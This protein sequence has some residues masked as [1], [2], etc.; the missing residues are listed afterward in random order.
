M[1]DI[2]KPV[3]G[4]ER[5]L[6]R[7]AIRTSNWSERWFPASLI[8]A[9]LVVIIVAIAAI[10]IGAPPPV[11][12]KSFGDGFWSMIT[13]TMQMAMVTI[14][15]YVVADSPP[16]KRLINALAR[17]PKTGKGAVSLVAFLS[18]FT[19]L[20]NWGMSLIFSGILVRRLADRDDLRVDYKAASAAGYLGLGATWALGL[21]SSAAQLQANPASIPDT[22]MKVTGVIPFTDT[23]F[24]WQSLTMAA[25]LLVMSNVIAHVTA[26]NDKNAKTAADLGI[27]TT[28][29]EPPP[30]SKSRPGE[31]LE[32]NPLLTII[33]G[34]LAIGWMIQ[35]FASQNFIIAISGLNTY[36]L[37][38]LTLGL[39][40]HWRPYRFIASVA[41]A[42]PAVG[43]VLIQ[44]PFYAGIATVMTDATNS[45]G[46]SVSHLLASMF[47]SLGHNAW[48]F[49]LVI[50]VYSMILGFLVPSGGGKWLVE[51]PYVMDA[52]NQTHYSLGWTVQIY[53]ASE[54][55][56][57]LINPFWMLPLLGVV[58]LKPRDI[59]GYTFIQLIFH[60]PVILLCLMLFGHT[61]PYIPPMIP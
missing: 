51:A 30:A 21:S 56:P 41:K 46:A 7:L 43:G 28:D 36:N 9:F 20:L 52:A 34:V 60:L 25:I 1:S 48:I 31:W 15:G 10:C 11:V 59:V 33:I 26:P 32:H 29:P 19:G 47:T 54:A 22:L 8:F 13:F 5:G 42:V 37:V 12:A 16:V 40:L 3:V 4:D 38:F 35:T 45:D 58:N 53:N 24:S 50:G 39:L 44:F 57:N 17:V 2:A 55:A 23:I 14:G 61:M 27:D 6:A 18:M 49:P